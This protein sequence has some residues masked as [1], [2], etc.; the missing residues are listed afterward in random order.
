MHWSCLPVA[1]VIN[2]FSFFYYYYEGEKKRRGLRQLVWIRAHTQRPVKGVFFLN[3]SHEDTLFGTAG[4]HWITHAKTYAHSQKIT[5]VEEDRFEITREN[6]VLKCWLL[7]RFWVRFP[8]LAWI[9]EQEH[10]TESYFDART[11]LTTAFFH[12]PW[13]RLNK[14]NVIC[15]IFQLQ[16]SPSLNSFSSKFNKRWVSPP[17]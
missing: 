11:E 1:F 3:H 9:S 2:M 4:P 10:D 16:V 6:S 13:A 15:S 12:W 7:Q 8:G 5:T 14:E 17:G